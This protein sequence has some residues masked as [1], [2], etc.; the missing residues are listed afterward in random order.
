MEA[1][2][3]SAATVVCLQ[4]T[5]YNLRVLDASYRRSIVPCDS[6]NRVPTKILTSLDRS[7]SLRDNV[8]W[9]MARNRS[10][11]LLQNFGA[12]APRHCD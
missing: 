9:A 11:V 4:A 5:Q 8:S 12:Q 3:S 7:N 1:K 2:L 10:N 6:E